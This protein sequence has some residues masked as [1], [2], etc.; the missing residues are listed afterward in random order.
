MKRQSPGRMS[1]QRVY[2]I[3][4]MLTFA[5][6]DGS[7]LWLIPNMIPKVG[8]TIIF[9]EGAV[10]KSF[11]IFDLCVA[12]ASEG[13]LFRKIEILANGP[14]FLVSTE[15]SKFQ[16][17][18][19]IIGNIRARE[20]FSAELL[21]RGEKP[22]I[23]NVKNLPLYYCQQ[24]YDFNDFE[25][26]DNFRRE[27]DKMVEETGKKPAMIVLDPL[28]SFLSGDENSSHET[29][30]FRKIMDDIIATYNTSVVIIHHAN[31]KGEIRGSTAW[32]GW[33]DSM[34][35]FKRR[36]APVKNGKES[37]VV[38]IKVEKIRD[39]E[40][41][42]G[43]A[44]ILTF[45]PEINVTRGINTFSIVDLKGDQDAFMHN[46]VAME[47]YDYVSQCGPVTQKEIMDAVKHSWK[48]VSN[49]LSALLYEGVV[50]QNGVVQRAAG[51][52][53]RQRPVPAWRVTGKTM[54]VDGVMSLLVG[55]RDREKHD[56]ETYEIE[57]IDGSNGSDVG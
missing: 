48:Q 57:I 50:D 11:F 18:R 21:K 6:D 53:D 5:N 7:D 39:G 45:H 26:V 52:D 34:L 1:R 29:S 44:T 10:F 19:R 33:A 3:E 37:T 56:A 51:G 38:D 46:T 42:K 25:D 20:G 13:L 36:K 14:V 16:N 8:R 24:P 41:P 54:A 28:A 12:V 2:N 17:A 49:A 47:V 31:K 30:Q 15:S 4:E 9:G 23:P 55:Q 35:E 40:P 22:L 27:L 32:R 43:N